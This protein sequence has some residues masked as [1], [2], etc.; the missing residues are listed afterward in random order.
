LTDAVKHL[1]A[2]G[3]LVSVRS[4]GASSYGLKPAED[5]RVESVAIR[6]IPLSFDFNDRYY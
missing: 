5:V 2:S 3:P 1:R 6:N 4:T